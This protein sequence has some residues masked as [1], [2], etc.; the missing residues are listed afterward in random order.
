MPFNRES[1]SNQGFRDRAPEFLATN[2]VHPVCQSPLSSSAVPVFSL[3]CFPVQKNERVNTSF[4]VIET[5]L[6]DWGEEYESLCP[7]RG[8]VGFAIGR[9]R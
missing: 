4:A 9:A 6:H 7:L 3:S 1:A 5:E 2:V 8:F